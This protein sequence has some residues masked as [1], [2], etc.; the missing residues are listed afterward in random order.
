MKRYTIWD[1]PKEIR[2]QFT[3][4]LTAHRQY[5]TE[6]GKQLGVPQTQLDIHDKSKWSEEEYPYYA[7]HFYGGGDPE[8]FQYAWLHHIHNNPHHWQYWVFPDGYSYHTSHPLSA[9]NSGVLEMPTNYLLEIVADWM[10]A[11][12]AYKGHWNMSEWLNENLDKIQLHPNSRVYLYSVLVGIGYEPK[13][14][15]SN[16]E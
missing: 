15:D 11:C 3:E 9:T 4:S 5:V 6:A 14:I 7:K 2:E 13:E 8:G 12:R 16:N 10:G 1:L